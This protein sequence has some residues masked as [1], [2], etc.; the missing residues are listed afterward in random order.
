MKAIVRNKYGSPDVLKLCEIDKPKP[1]DNQVLV[2]IHAA[3]VNPL[4]WHVLRGKPFLV[5]LMGFGLLKPKQQILGA[6]IAGRVEAV[7]KDVTQFRIGDEIIGSG[8]GGFAEYACYR[9]SRLVTKPATITFEQAAAVPVA[10]IT[11]LQGL[12]DHGRI[13]PGHHVLINGAS[14]GVGTFAVQIAKALGAEVT[15]VCSTKNIEM[16]RSIGADHVI[17]YTKEDYWRSGKKYDL[18]LDNNAGRSLLKPVRALNP[19]G[20]YVFVG[21]SAFILT[22]LQQLIFKPLFSRK[23]GRKIVSFVAN[24]NQADMTLLKEL[25]EAGKVVSIIDRKYSLSETPQ[26]IRYLEEGHAQGKV[27][28]TIRQ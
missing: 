20:I 15:G 18:I 4:D 27:I 19:A 9:E 26:A 6:D 8:L 23:A 2:E 24:V 13:Q 22:M 25:L 12:R 10:G 14:G 28:I 21:G 1:K 3:S 17:D 5:R 16:V 7:G 11:A